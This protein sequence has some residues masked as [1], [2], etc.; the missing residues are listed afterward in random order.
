MF[1][2]LFLSIDT[3]W[4]NKGDEVEALA[5]EFEWIYIGNKIKINCHYILGRTKTWN[6]D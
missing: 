4:C 6:G 1:R 3:F 2:V 5:H